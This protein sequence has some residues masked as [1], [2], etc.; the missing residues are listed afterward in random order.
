LEGFRS[1][2][3]PQTLDLGAFAPGLYLVSGVNE[4]EPDLE[5]N[6]AGKSSLFEA[7]YWALYGKTSR[8]LKGENV[9]AWRYK[10][11][12]RV[13]LQ[14]GKD[15]VQRV[16][17]RGITLSLSGK[18]VDQAEVDAYVRLSPD[19]FLHTC[20]FAQF[21]PAFIDLSPASRMEL[22]A[23]IMGLEFWEQK[24]R[25]AA[26]L[27]KEFAQ[28]LSAASLSV[29]EL[30]GQLQGL[31][32]QDFTEAERE[33]KARQGAKLVAL[34]Q[35]LQE[36]E[37]EAERVARSVAVTRRDAEGWAADRKEAD[38]KLRELERTLLELLE[39]SRR[40]GYEQETN[41]AAIEA[42]EREEQGMLKAGAK[43]RACGQEVRPEA[44]RQHRLHLR[45]RFVEL[46][47]QAR[48]LDKRGK[49]VKKK[50]QKAEEELAEFKE[51]LPDNSKALQMLELQRSHL[52]TLQ[53]RIKQKRD[54][55]REVRD[56][57]SPWERQRKL[58][59]KQEKRVRQQLAKAKEARTDAQW[60][61][62]AF[63]FWA[64]QLKD[65][66]FFLIQESLRQLNAEANE[67]LVQLGLV[68]W[69]IEF[70]V[71]KETKGGGV[72]RGFLVN[73]QGPETKGTAVPWEAWS[74]GESQRL[75]L[76]V[77][78]GISNLLSARSGVS[79]DFEF[80]DEPSN[81]LSEGGI[82]NLLQTLEERATRYQ[83]RIFIADHRSL[84]FNCSGGQ[85][86]VIKT[87]KGSKIRTEL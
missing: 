52:T 14:F 77:Q 84:D 35:E 80:W 3:S 75:R 64:K 31:K 82:K 56:D 40:I 65:I 22:Y 26:A 87:D 51:Q 68:D 1:F 4:V 44:V 66:R 43:C 32:A 10:G 53:E 46:G 5:A 86:V 71:E 39:Q 19:A 79:P 17:A 16:R 73:V 69:S 41:A 45:T 20:Y 81:W 57:E 34:T 13:E 78:L 59:A 18:E 61:E 54:R 72:K 58:F 63:G 38:K 55:V 33:W 21:S 85:L 23:E 28:E 2:R 36:L 24:A 42:L 62:N 76:A 9:K 7:V 25:T 49:E 12:C 83:R 74:G 30:K 37:Q 6:G 67:C 47:A 48:V 60:H 15:V 29:S 70:A 8:N 50:R 11:P 27:Q